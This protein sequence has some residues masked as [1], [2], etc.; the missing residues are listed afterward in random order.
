MQKDI[1]HWVS[2]AEYDLKTADAMLKSRRYLYV[3]FTC[4]QAVEKMLKALV[5]KSTNQFPPK[6]H[7]LLRLA[8]LSNID[9]DDSGKEFLAKLTFY[10]IE[11]RYPQEI[12]QISKDINK[13]IAFEYLN[14]TKALLK[15]LKRKLK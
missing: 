15:W 7:D 12:S 8:E 9:I 6:T 11:T 1:D 2:L 14:N 5:T 3:L 10:Y 13:K 4:Q